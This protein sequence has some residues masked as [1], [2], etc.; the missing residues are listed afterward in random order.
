MSTLDLVHVATNLIL[1]KR[2][3]VTIAT[4]VSVTRAVTIV[5]RGFAAIATS[6]A[7]AIVFR[8]KTLHRDGAVVSAIAVSGYAP[9]V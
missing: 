1:M 2:A 5:E 4:S 9:S 8:N 7:A 3:C 6:S